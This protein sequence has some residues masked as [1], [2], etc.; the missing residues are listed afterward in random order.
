MVQIYSD[1]TSIALRANV[2]VTYPVHIVLRNFAKDFGRF[3]IYHR[4]IIAALLPG[5]VSKF[6]EK[7]KNDH[8]AED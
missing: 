5:S 6:S 2:T 7:T 1:K 3:Q 8:T 4:H